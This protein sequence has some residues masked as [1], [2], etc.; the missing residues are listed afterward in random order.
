MKRG[1]I[2]T[3]SGGPDYAGKPRPSV[4]LQDSRFEYLSSV[5]VCPLTTNAAEAS[6]LRPSVRPSQTN[7]LKAPCRLMVDKITTVSKAK[8]RTRVGKLDDFDMIRLDRA[9]F[10]FLGFAE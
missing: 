6:Y 10:V 1:E 3:T 4:I 8:L 9:A 7:G 5:T 2:W